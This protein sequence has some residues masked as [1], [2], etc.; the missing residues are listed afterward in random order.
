MI[1]LDGIRL[2]CAQIARA[3]HRE[4]PVELAEA[5]R[6][7]AADSYRVAAEISAQRPVYGR[8]TG[9]GAN[10]G[11][12]VDDPGVH[13]VSLLR[14]HATAAGPVRSAERIRAML[15][16]RLNQLAAGGSGADPSVLDGL[17]AMIQADALPAVREHGGIGTGDLSALATTALALMGEGPTS[18]PLPS[19]TGFS[20]HDALPFL[21]SNAAT[22]ADAALA[23]VDLEETI[24]AAVV[25][26]AL[27]FA[28]VDGN[29]EAFSAA[30]DRAT[31]FAG[32]RQVNTWLRALTAT[33][34]PPAR[35]QD[36]LGLRVLPQSQGAALDSLRELSA[37]IVRMV[38]APSENPVLLSDEP[39]DA[40]LAHHGGFHASYLQMALDSAVLGVAQTGQLVLGRLAALIEPSFTGLAP[41]LGDGFAG[42]SGVM[43]L[44]YV[45]AS[46]LAEVRAAA[47]PAGLQSVTL[48]RGVEE[49]ASFASLAARQAL[50]ATGNYRTLVACE[51]LAAVRALR[52]QARTVPSGLRPVLEL[53]EDLPRSTVDR[54]L[55]PDVDVAVA[56]LPALATILGEAG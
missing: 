11:V 36:P 37:T 34:L 47:T 43:I 52:M 21:S 22:L 15:V 16:I 9:V 4:E 12:P 41:F 5:G 42:A 27:T 7:R 3:A 14:S 38:N 46:A 45:A 53:C 33:D 29:R 40:A 23:F 28:A 20:A 24:R 39:V 10:R 35:I 31:P 1:E 17:A 51:L 6:K 26:A 50:T 54:D 32:A 44:E 56:L 25:V 18:T 8:S 48:S 13:A 2:S 19:I 55:T 30:A 49:D